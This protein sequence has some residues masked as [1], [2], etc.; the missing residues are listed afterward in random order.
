M[1]AKLLLAFARKAV[2]MTEAAG[3]G[4]A[5]LTGAG[6]VSGNPPRV[7]LSVSSGERDPQP[8]AV[9]LTLVE[10]RRLH[11]NPLNE[12]GGRICCGPFEWS[13]SNPLIAKLDVASN[14]Q[15]A[16]LYPVEL[17]QCAVTVTGSK[18]EVTLDVAVVE[19]IPATLNLVADEPEVFRTL[20]TVDS[21]VA[22]VL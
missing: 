13:L 3:G 21:G 19:A 7:T 9:I 17:G 6:N 20:E 8:P 4:A 10:R 2:A 12:Y 15:S 14:T 11:V 16:W 1:F 5:A 22:G 18:R